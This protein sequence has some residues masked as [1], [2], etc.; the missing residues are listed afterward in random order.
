MIELARLMLLRSRQTTGRS[1]VGEPSVFGFVGVQRRRSTPAS[2]VERIGRE[3]AGFGYSVATA[4]EEALSAPTEWFSNVEQAHDFVLYAADCDQTAWKH[5]GRPP[6]RPAV[7]RRPRRRCAAGAGRPAI[8]S[9]HPAGRCW[10][11]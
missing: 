6:G 10:S 9:A 5:A 3:I 2:F 11:T 8:A 1:A 7:P 4:G